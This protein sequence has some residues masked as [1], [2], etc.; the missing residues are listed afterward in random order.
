MIQFLYHGEHLWV[1]VP[2]ESKLAYMIS[3]VIN[4]LYSSGQY[5]AMDEMQGKG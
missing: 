1:I 3:L 2:H 4:M 5:N